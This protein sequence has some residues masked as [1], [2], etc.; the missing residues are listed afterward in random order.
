MTKS[1]KTFL[2]VISLVVLLAAAALTVTSCAQTKPTPAD[3][4]A[5][6][7]QSVE[8][9]IEIKVVDDKGQETFYSASTQCDTLRGVL[10]EMEIVE[11]EDGEYGLYIKTVAGIT[12]DYDTDG[13]YWALSKGGEYLMTS[14]DDTPIADGDVFELTYTK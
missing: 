8:K 12:A 10:E 13:A 7:A 14:A 1:R 4:S 5:V 6:S 9:T 2:S 11:G 3:T